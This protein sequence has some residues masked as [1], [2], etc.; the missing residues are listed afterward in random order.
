MAIGRRAEGRRPSAYTSASASSTAGLKSLVDGGAFGGTLV[1]PSSVVLGDEQRLGRSGSDRVKCE[2]R[3]VGSYHG[4][5]EMA[6]D[7]IAGGEEV[8]DAVTLREPWV[9]PA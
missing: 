4:G 2:F 9:S 8:I 5:V 3:V 7:G 6:D 1:F